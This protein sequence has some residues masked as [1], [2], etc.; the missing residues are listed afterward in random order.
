MADRDWLRS[1]HEGKLKLVDH[2]YR[3]SFALAVRWRGTTVVRRPWATVSADPGGV[4][5]D[6]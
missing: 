2:G 3:F 5:G 6:S 1:L 4:S